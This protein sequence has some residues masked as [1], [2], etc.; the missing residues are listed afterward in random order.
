MKAK[1]IIAGLIGLVSIFL[2]CISGCLL[3]G[4]LSQPV[5]GKSIVCMYKVGN[6]ITGVERPVINGLVAIIVYGSIWYLAMKIAYRIL[7]KSLISKKEL[8]ISS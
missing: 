6:T 7:I 8:I 1:K 3:T 4:E 5:L 2:V